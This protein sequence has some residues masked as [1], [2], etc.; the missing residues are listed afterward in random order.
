MGSCVLLDCQKRIILVLSGFDRAADCCRDPFT[1]DSRA[2]EQIVGFLGE[3]EGFAGSR[4]LPSVWGRGVI[5]SFDLLLVL[6]VELLH[7]C[8]LPVLELDK[9]PAMNSELWKRPI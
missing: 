3:R 6:K 4:R 1:G 8:L 9:S 5:A 7:K 2:S